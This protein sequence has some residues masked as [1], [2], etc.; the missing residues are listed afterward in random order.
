MKFFLKTYGCQM[1]VYDSARIKEMMLTDNHQF[2]DKI[3][4]ADIYIVNT[5][6]VRDKPRQRVIN[7]IKHAKNINPRLKVIITGCVAQIEGDSLFSEGADFVVG[8]DWYKELPSLA[9]HVD[10]ENLNRDH[11]LRTGF[12]VETPDFLQADP[13]KTG[14]SAFIP[15]QKGCNNFCAYCVVPYGRGPERS[16]SVDEI[17]KEI[18]VFTD[19]GVKEFFLLGQNVNSYHYKKV[20]FH[21]LLSKIATLT[22]VERIRFTTSHP[23]DL[24]EQLISTMASTPELMPWFHLPLQSGS[25][26][27]LKLMRRNYTRE[28]YLKLVHELRRQIENISLTTDVIVGFPGESEED[29]VETYSLVEQVGYDGMFSFKFSVRQGTAAEKMDNHL[30]EQIKKQRLAR[31]QSMFETQIS[32][33]LNRFSGKVFKVLVEGSSRRNKD[34][35]KGRIPQN[36]FV[37]FRLDGDLEP[38]ELVNQ[39]V[40]VKILEVRTH[41]LYGKIV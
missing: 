12:K 18:S 36:I 15:I 5:C 7:H 13:V 27:I 9:N 35:A 39:I 11:F 16:R 41:T 3:E 1:N 40:D 23:R 20:G 24:S 26:R 21:N 29:F 32:N 22:G 8:P 2:V 28:H 31:L 10:Q 25:N 37:N 38:S 4:Y 33:N 34:E 14:V 30:P 17:L 6:S 19:K